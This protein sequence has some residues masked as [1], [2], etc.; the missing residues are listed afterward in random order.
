MYKLFD[1]NLKQLSIM[2]QILQYHETN[3]PTYPKQLSIMVQI[4]QYHGTNF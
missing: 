3:P 1:A 2:I 4:V